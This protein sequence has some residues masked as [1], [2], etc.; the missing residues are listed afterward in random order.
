ML[1]ILFYPYPDLCL[2]YTINKRLH[3][4]GRILAYFCGYMAVCIQS[5]S[6]RVVTQAMTNNKLD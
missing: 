2:F 4:A 1:K 3:P 6:S 5:E